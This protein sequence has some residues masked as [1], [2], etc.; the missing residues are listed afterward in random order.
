MGRTTAEHERVIDVLDDLVAFGYAYEG[1]SVA[2]GHLGRLKA[3]ADEVISELRKGPNVVTFLEPHEQEYAIIGVMNRLKAAICDDALPEEVDFNRAWANKPSVLTGHFLQK[4]H[5]E[6]AS[7][8]R[9]LVAAV[10]DR[11]DTAF[12]PEAKQFITR[13]QVKASVLAMMQNMPSFT[14]PIHVDTLAGL[15]HQHFLMVLEV[16]EPPLGNPRRWQAMT[17][18]YMRQAEGKLLEMVKEAFVTSMVRQLF[19]RAKDLHISIDRYYPWGALWKEPMQGEELLHLYARL[20]LSGAVVDAKFKQDTAER[21][22]AGVPAGEFIRWGAAKCPRAIKSS[23]VPYQIYFN[24]D[25][26][27]I[28]IDGKVIQKHAVM[29]I[30]Y[31]KPLQDVEKH[32]RHFGM[33]L[34]TQRKR[35]CANGQEPLS[36]EEDAMAR[37]IEVDIVGRRK[38]S[39]AVLHDKS[40]LLGHICALISLQ[41]QRN[42]LYAGKM[43]K[44]QMLEI[45]DLVRKAGFKYG[46]E[47]IRKAC[48]KQDKVME[49]LRLHL[50]RA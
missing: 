15:L 11:L 30:R 27:D 46:E 50:A 44:V 23:R 20:N 45:H 42:P 38:A 21:S 6:Q 22:D 31:D 34:L 25:D 37:R 39:R 13:E 4:V 8:L 47:S 32:L 48:D 33:Y 3:L 1:E 12:P 5:T 41:L 18:E 26:V 28:C 7:G 10:I 2:N 19:S 24:T 14:V 36:A 17:E 9:K 16:D 40:S 49:E 43:K 35:H 29:S